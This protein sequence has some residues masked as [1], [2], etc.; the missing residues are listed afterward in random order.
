[1]EVIPGAA[2]RRLLAAAGALA[3]CACTSRVAYSPPPPAPVESPLLL[4][5]PFDRAWN[6]VIQ[7]FFEGNIPVRTVEKAS[8]ILESDEL[9]GEV[10]R[11]CDCGTY[12]GIGIGGYGG[13]YGGDAY[14]RFRILVETRGADQTA[15]SLRSGCRARVDAVEGELVCRLAPAKEVELRQKIS[16]RA[17]R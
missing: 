6:A 9:R 11:E 1:S 12:L 13:A 14:Y 16:E 10:G 17:G 8:G 7:T 5:V 4:A 15:V 3:L 2:G